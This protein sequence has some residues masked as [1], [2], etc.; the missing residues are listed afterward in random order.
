MVFV[1]ALEGNFDGVVCMYHDQANIARKLQP[2]E[3]GAT[4]FMGLPVVCGTTAHG[5]AFDKAGLGI[6]DPGSLKAALRYTVQL[7]SQTYS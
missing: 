5:T 2:K 3:G 4:I 6:A 7:S 1:L